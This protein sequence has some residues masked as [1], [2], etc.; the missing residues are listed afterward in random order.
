[1]TQKQIIGAASR[2]QVVL[3]IALLI[4]QIAG[5]LKGRGAGSH[6]GTPAAS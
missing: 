5:L 1:M 2:G 3:S 4:L 6:A